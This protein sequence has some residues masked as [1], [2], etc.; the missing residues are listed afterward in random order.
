MVH[1]SGTATD[2]DIGHLINPFSE[3]PPLADP[4]NLAR[5]GAHF[6]PEKS[7]RPL[8]ATRRLGRGGEDSPARGFGRD[9]LLPPSYAVRSAI[10]AIPSV[11]MARRRWR[12]FVGLIEDSTK[13]L[14]LGDR[15]LLG[16][17]LSGH[18][19]ETGFP[20]ASG[21]PTTLRQTRNCSPRSPSS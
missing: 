20:R 5:F 19:V 15:S 4:N 21:T 17:F 1:G 18:H 7:S 10:A 16:R 9:H 11:W 12:T 14:L 6:I 3:Q 8:G 13:S 2:W